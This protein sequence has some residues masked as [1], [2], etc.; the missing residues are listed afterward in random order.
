MKQRSKAT[1]T[2]D[3]NSVGPSNLQVYLK[4]ADG[5]V[6]YAWANTDTNKPEVATAQSIEPGPYMLAVRIKPG[7]APTGWTV[8]VNLDSLEAPTTT[9]TAP[10]A[11][12]VPL[13]RPA[14]AECACRRRKVPRRRGPRLRPLGRR[15]RVATATRLPGTRPRPVR[16]WASV[17]AT[18]AGTG[19]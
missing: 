16:P 7:T 19:G 8:S 12:T 2:L 15:G 5:T 3:W 18:S 13:V 9:T 11:T 6:D 1:L 10:P 17:A 14:E 4:S